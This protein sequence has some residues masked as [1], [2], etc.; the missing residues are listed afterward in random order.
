MRFIEV[1]EYGEQQFYRLT[2]V[3]R[4]VFESGIYTSLALVDQETHPTLMKEYGLE[5]YFNG[6]QG[7]KPA[8]IPDWLVYVHAGSPKWREF[9]SDKMRDVKRQYGNRPFA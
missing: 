7:D 6:I 4:G 5:P 2:G 8:T 1:S 9:Y 3:K